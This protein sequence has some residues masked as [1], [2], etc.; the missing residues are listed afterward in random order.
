G[1][2][3]TRALVVPTYSIDVFSPKGDK[4]SHIDSIA[5]RI[6]A[7]APIGD[8]DGDGATDLVVGSGNGAAAAYSWTASGFVLKPGWMGASTCSEGACPETRGR[9]AADLDGDGKI[10]TVFTTTTTATHGAQVFVFNADGTIYQPQ[11]ASGFT[12]WPRYNNATGTG[13]DA[14]FNGE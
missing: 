5:D 7:P 10:E 11:S 13:N 1:S 9:A 12:A 14:D 8:I 2:S 3:K 6:Y 4:L